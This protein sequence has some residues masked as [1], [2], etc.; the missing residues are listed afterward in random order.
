MLGY[1]NL[2]ERN[3][4]AFETDSDG[5]RWYKT[6]DVVIEDDDRQLPVPSAAAT[7]WSSAAA[8]ASSSAKSKPR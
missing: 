1:W 3:A 2:P 7:A 4:I 8:I 5:V 6:G